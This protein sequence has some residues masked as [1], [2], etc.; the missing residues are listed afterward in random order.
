MSYVRYMWRQCSRLFTL[1]TEFRKK[2]AWPTVTVFIIFFGAIRRIVAYSS[3]KYRNWCQ[4]DVK[5]FTQNCRCNIQSASNSWLYLTMHIMCHKKRATLLLS[6]SLPII[7]RFSKFFHW[8]IPQTICNN[9]II[10]YPTHS[11]CVS[12]LLSEASTP[13]TGGGKC[14]LEKIGG[15]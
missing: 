11:K 4:T 7:E 13:L 3:T 5:H 9:V 6:I 15:K 14:L 10:I 12:T 2:T 8:H 1:S